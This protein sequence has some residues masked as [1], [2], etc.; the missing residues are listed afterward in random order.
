MLEELAVTACT[1]VIQ[2]DRIKQAEAAKDR[3]RRRRFWIGVIAVLVVAVG[4]V[5][6]VIYRS[7]QPSDDEVLYQTILNEDAVCNTNYERSHH[8][9]IVY[10]QVDLLND[11]EGGWVD[12]DNEYPGAVPTVGG[13]ELTP[14]QLQAYKTSEANVD[15]EAYVSN[16]SHYMRNTA[17]LERQGE[18]FILTLFSSQYGFQ[19]LPHASLQVA[20]PL[21]ATVQAEEF[22]SACS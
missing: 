1:Q 14:A 16:S 15:R 5:S 12:L 22:S 4:I 20:N 21:I 17:L 10:K 9:K 19:E 7:S 3:S 8:L 2:Q 11:G 13:V 6:V 18:Q